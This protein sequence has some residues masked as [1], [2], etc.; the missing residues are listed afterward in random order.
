MVL[1]YYL[2]INNPSDFLQILKNPQSLNI[3]EIQK[4][5]ELCKDF[6]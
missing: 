6:L 5:N 4:P 3:K 1:P 2:G